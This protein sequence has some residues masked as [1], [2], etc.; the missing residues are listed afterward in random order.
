M[1]CTSGPKDAAVSEK[2]AKPPDETADPSFVKKPNRAERVVGEKS[3]YDELSSQT[4]LEKQKEK[5][6]EEDVPGE[7]LVDKRPLQA[8]VLHVTA[9]TRG[10]CNRKPTFHFQSGE[11]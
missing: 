7:N 5:V 11:D 10:W 3:P 9:P 2:L 4:G 8:R 6:T 1:T